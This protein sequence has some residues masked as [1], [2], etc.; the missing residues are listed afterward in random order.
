M[1][2]FEN[3]LSSE[4]ISLKESYVRISYSGRRYRI[5]EKNLNKVDSLVENVLSRVDELSIAWLTCN[6]SCNSI[7]KEIT[8]LEDITLPTIYFESYEDRNNKIYKIL[9]DVDRIIVVGQNVD[10]LRN[11]KIETVETNYELNDNCWTKIDQLIYS[12]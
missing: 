7:Y 8:S 5:S 2:G 3:C 10:E 6:Q 4:V 11:D 9:E 1:F 12:N